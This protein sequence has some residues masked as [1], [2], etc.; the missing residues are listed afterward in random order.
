M[1]EGRTG[2]EHLLFQHTFQHHISVGLPWKNQLVILQYIKFLISHKLCQFL[3]ICCTST[4]FINPYSP[5]L[6]ILLLV[7]CLPSSARCFPG[8]TRLLSSQENLKPCTPAEP[9]ELFQPHC[10]CT[11]WCSKW[12][13]QLWAI[14]TLQWGTGRAQLTP[15]LWL[16]TPLLEKVDFNPEIEEDPKLHGAKGWDSTRDTTECFRSAPE[17]L[18]L[19]NSPSSAP[20]PQKTRQAILASHF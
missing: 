13:T 18:I 17:K 8:P 3:E 6:E 7:S 4:Q 2:G 1:P 5:E 20:D 9:W 10:G 12:M 16:A 14:L 19:W 11:E 15:Y